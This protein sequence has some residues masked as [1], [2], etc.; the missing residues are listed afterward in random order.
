MV[1]EFDEQIQ[2][3][4]A[5]WKAPTA[6]GLYFWVVEDSRGKFRKGKLSV[7]R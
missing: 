1:T 2:N 4:L 6:G 7:I 5:I 3:G